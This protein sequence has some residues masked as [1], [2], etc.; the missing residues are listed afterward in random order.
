MK[1]LNIVGFP[2]YSVTR[3]GQVYSI[4]S[5]KFLKTYVRDDGYCIVSLREGTQTK[6]HRVHRIVAL[7][8]IPVVEG[9][10]HVNHIDGNKQNNRV[11]NLEW[12]NRSENML[13]AHETGLFVNRPRSLVD[14]DVHT[15]CR[16]FEQG[17]RPVDI[18]KMFGVDSAIIH[19]IARGVNYTYIS[20]EYDLTKV[21]KH[22][23]LSDTKVIQIC[24][25]L[26]EG[27][28]VREINDSTQVPES[29][30][31]AIRQRRIY[32]HISDSFDW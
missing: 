23:K 28:K 17:A 3:D 15:I 19:N 5:G 27:F 32:R 2:H 7:A 12:V 6:I 8:Y 29:T 4:K 1:S 24:N 14:D 31:K 13:H 30:V 11:E 26:S 25:M 16:M 10:P 18:S 22:Q 21:P 20:C 9:K